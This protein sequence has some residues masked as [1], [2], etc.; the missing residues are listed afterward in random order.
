MRRFRGVW[1]QLR[2]A[3]HDAAA[4]SWWHRRRVR[5]EREAERVFEM[6]P[7]LLAVAGLTVT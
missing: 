5:A 1:A 7:A 4:P 3:M 2:A 6:S